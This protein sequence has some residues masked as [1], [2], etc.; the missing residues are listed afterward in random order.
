MEK[1]YYLLID[2]FTVIFPF[3]LSFDKKVAFYKHWKRLG[4]GLLVGG[5]IFLIWDHV[6][7]INGVWS[8]NEKYIT[9]IKIA[10]LPIEE[11]LFFLVVPYACIFVIHCVEA[12]FPKLSEIKHLKYFWFFVYAL[13]IFM[14]VKYNDR[15]Y[16]LITFS[17]LAIVAFIFFN[18][19]KK[20]HAHFIFGYIISLIPFFIVNGLLTSIPI[21]L[22]DDTENI[23][24][25][26]GSIPF[27]D[28]FYMMALLMLNVWVMRKGV[29]DEG[30]R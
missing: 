30:N 19:Y 16:T 4:F 5:I 18:N 22:Y 9:G 6:F 1:Y 26:W 28:S 15:L 23:A 2:F 10:S 27:E 29:E 13:S 8:F 20:W 3:L 17:L 25:R 12:Y 21:V 14:I 11:V 24:F 7:T